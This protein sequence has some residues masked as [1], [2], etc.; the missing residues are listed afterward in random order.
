MKVD[1]L[2]RI[3]TVDWTGGQI[4]VITILLSVYSSLLGIM[5]H[6]F[7]RAA[8]ICILNMCATQCCLGSLGAK[9]GLTS[10]FVAVGR[11]FG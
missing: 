10:A 1:Q 11:R 8:H 4:K 9:S 2:F 6:T 3:E 5:R 7:A